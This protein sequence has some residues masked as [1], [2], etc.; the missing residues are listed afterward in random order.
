MPVHIANASIQYPHPQAHC[1]YDTHILSFEK[2]GWVWGYELS[3]LWHL[4]N[5]MTG[6]YFPLWLHRCEAISLKQKKIADRY[7]EQRWLKMAMAA[8]KGEMTKKIHNAYLFLSCMQLSTDGHLIL[9]LS[10]WSRH[11]QGSWNVLL[12]GEWLQRGTILWKRNIMHM[13]WVRGVINVLLS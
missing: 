9:E 11:L 4:Y 13:L 5:V 1:S 7:C 12:F 10:K 6:S 3:A 2:L 8:W